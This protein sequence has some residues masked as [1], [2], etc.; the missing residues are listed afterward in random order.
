MRKPMCAILALSLLLGCTSAREMKVEKVLEKYSTELASPA[1]LATDGYV[2]QSGIEYELETTVR[3]EGDRLVFA[4]EE[5]EYSRPKISEVR[6]I[7]FERLD[8][9]K[10]AGSTGKGVL[11]TL[12]IALLAILTLGVSLAG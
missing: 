10:T 2:T 11:A 6:G 9:G 5:L 7:L 12:A 3:R 8:A 1:G 4:G